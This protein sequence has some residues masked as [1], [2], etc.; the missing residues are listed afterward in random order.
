MLF[1]TLGL[2]VL[3]AAPATAES[4]LGECSFDGVTVSSQITVGYD[5]AF[6]T[7]ADFVSDVD[8]SGPIVVPTPVFGIANAVAN[9]LPGGGGLAK[10]RVDGSMKTSFEFGSPFGTTTQDTLLFD[11]SGNASAVNSTNTAGSQADATVIGKAT[12]RFDVDIVA[13][14]DCDTF[15][16]VPEVPNL[17]PFETFIEINVFR[18]P[19]PSQVLEATLSP[20][21]PAQLVLL[22]EDHS[23]LIDFEYNYRVPFGVDPP[24]GFEYAITVGETPSAVP[25]LSPRSAIVLGLLLLGTAA[26]A[27][28]R[29]W[30]RS[31]PTP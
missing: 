18:D 27:A 11:A 30:M 4:I 21:S 9:A 31:V 16:T 26:L 3:S 7:A 24:F 8:G 10:D 19:G 22:P 13:G 12:A 25:L 14:K 5:G 23:Y 17:Q 28:R 15:L 29:S 6:S 1:F 2:F 20:G